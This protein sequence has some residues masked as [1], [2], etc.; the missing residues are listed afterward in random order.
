[1]EERERANRKRRKGGR[2][3]KEK[4]EGEGRHTAKQVGCSNHRV[5]T[6]VADKLK[7]HAVVMRG[8]LLHCK[9]IWVTSTIFWSS[10]LHA[11]C[12]CDTLQNFSFLLNQSLSVIEKLL[13]VGRVL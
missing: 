4:R 1:M 11:C 2:T 13:Q 6:V 12:V 5:V 8:S 7:R 10:Q 9:K 3:E